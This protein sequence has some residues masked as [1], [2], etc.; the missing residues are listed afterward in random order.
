MWRQMIA[1]KAEEWGRP[2][3]EALDMMPVLA[4][5]SR[6]CVGAGASLAE[7]GEEGCHE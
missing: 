5:I 7:V 2:G 6:A 4:G 1:G 3:A